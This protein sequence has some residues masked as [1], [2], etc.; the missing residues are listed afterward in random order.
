MVH[1][2]GRGDMQAGSGHRLSELT[3]LQIEVYRGMDPGRK[4]EIAMA[5]LR[6]A[7]ELQRAGVRWRNPSFGEEEVERAVRR[8]ASH[9]R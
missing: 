8:L 5:L 4:V 7:R 6:M 2:G 3:D 1:A 9:G